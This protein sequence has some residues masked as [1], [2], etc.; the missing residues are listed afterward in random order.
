MHQ[1]PPYVHS[2]WAWFRKVIYILPLFF[3]LSLNL[4]YENAKE[5]VKL[6]CIEKSAHECFDPYKTKSIIL[7]SRLLIM[8][9]IFH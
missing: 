3:Q 6:Y 9:L 2:M 7:N 1:M 5:K 8:R 4:K